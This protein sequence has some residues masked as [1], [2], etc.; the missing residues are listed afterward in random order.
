MGRQNALITQIYQWIMQWN[1]MQMY[2][3]DIF[4]PSSSNIKRIFKRNTM[5][6]IGAVYSNTF[7]N[8]QSLTYEPTKQS[9]SNSSMN[10]TYRLSGVLT[11]Q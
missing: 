7:Q 5:L 9:S 2:P 3:Y 11:L 1:C 4:S 6:S 8:F 10:Y